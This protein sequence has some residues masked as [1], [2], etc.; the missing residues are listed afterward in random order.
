MQV[1]VFKPSGHRLLD[2][3]KDLGPD[4]VGCEIGVDRGETTKYLLESL[5]AIQKLYLIDPW[6]A[7]MDSK[8]G[9]IPQETV[10]ESK[11]IALENI[12]PHNDRVCL[13]EDTSE[14]AA[15]YISANILDFIFIDG[16]H[17]YDAVCSDIDLFWPKMK[18]GGV[19]SGDDYQ[20][21]E[22]SRAV[23]EFATSKG[24]QKRVIDGV[25]WS[26]TKVK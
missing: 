16:D 18:V 13:I 8:Y 3:I 9:L 7:F 14:A 1:K 2:L 26:F 6:E 5:P 19:F 23:D 22:V 21:K 20:R 10:D 4:L 17:N 15:N 25:L 11:R 24:L 12:R